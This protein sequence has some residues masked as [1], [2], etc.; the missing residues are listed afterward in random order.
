MKIKKNVKD[1]GWAAL[2]LALS[3][4]VGPLGAELG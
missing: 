4:R 1:L 2:A 3:G